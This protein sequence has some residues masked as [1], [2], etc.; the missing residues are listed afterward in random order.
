MSSGSISDIGH[1]A[2]WRG[3][4]DLYVRTFL[5]FMLGVV[6]LWAI[7]IEGIYGSPLPFYALPFRASLLSVWHLPALSV[8]LC[9]GAAALAAVRRLDWFDQEPSRRA[10]AW[11]LIG[12][13]AFSILFSCSVAMI[14]EGLNGISQAYQRHGYEY[15][16]DI[17]STRDIRTL[18]GD[19]LRLRP[20]LSM[21][22]KVHPP[23]PIAL[24]WIPSMFIGQDPLALS[25]VTVVFGTLAVIPLYFWVAELFSKRMALT[26]CVL[27]SLVPG[28]VLF[29]A[30]SADIMFMP[31]T[32]TTIYAFTRALHRGSIVWALLGGIGYAILSLL[33]FSLLSIGAFFAFFGLWRLTQ[34]RSPRIVIQTAA[35]MLAA[36]FVTQLAV[37]WWSGF[38]IVACFNACKAQF[39]LDQANLDLVTPRFPA[40]AWKF[41]NPLCWFYF[42]GIPVSLLFL[43]RF[44][45]SETF[46]RA[47]FLVFAATLLA[48]DL[49][50]LARGEGERSAMYLYPFLVIP[51][52]HWLD[53]TG[54]NMRSYAPLV[55]TVV[56]L[57]FQCWFTE[58]VFYTFW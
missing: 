58:T 40:W 2:V 8:F 53:E 45:K 35:L 13:V 22:A 23:G 7:G 46:S 49:M 19:Y 39:D 5:W 36:F 52:A 21:H 3:L 6:V 9:F 56:F 55:V 24:L 42:A 17:G 16:S 32:L 11:F 25:L 44:R 28:I 27:Y 4:A 34:R 15:V 20:F 50:Y 51:A 43:R 41:V 14:R 47:L 12:L 1:R 26:A 38:D 10:M 31:F 37:R 30:T 54:R 48:F 33:S 18:F 29:T 57:A